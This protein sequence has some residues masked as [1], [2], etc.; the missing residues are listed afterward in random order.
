MAQWTQGISAEEYA[1][2]LRVLLRAVSL[3][4]VDAAPAAARPCGGEAG[5]G[6]GGGGDG[7]DDG[8]NRD[9]GDGRGDGGGDDGGG[10]PRNRPR[11]LRE[12]RPLDT[13]GFMNL[14]D[15]VYVPAPAE[16]KALRDAEK[17]KSMALRA[18]PP[19]IPVRLTER[20]LLVGREHLNRPFS[21]RLWNGMLEDVAAANSLGRPTAATAAAWSFLPDRRQQLPL[22]ALAPP[23]SPFAS[24]SGSQGASPSSSL[25]SSSSARWTSVTP[26]VHALARSFL[27]G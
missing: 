9:G 6:D 26:S 14:A 5:D 13:V 24:S 23:P 25:S 21:P 16:Q 10:G 27:R 4:R 3:P 15:M 22:G 8:S 18:K 1:Q 19:K 12:L 20:P 7:G 2:F 17:V 11:S